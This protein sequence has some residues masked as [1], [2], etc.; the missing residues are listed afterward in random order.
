MKI[1]KPKFYIRFIF[2]APVSWWNKCIVF[3]G[4]KRPYIAPATRMRP[5]LEY[6]EINL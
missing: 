4:W 1:G 6:L 2:F 3:D 5:Q